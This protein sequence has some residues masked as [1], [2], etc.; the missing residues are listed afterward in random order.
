MN[1][2][3]VLACALALSLGAACSS[4]LNFTP[5]ATA[6]TVGADL[7]VRAE[8]DAAQHLTRVRVRAE[9]LA[10]PGR[11]MPEGR[12][13][14]VWARANANTTWVR[15][16]TLVYDT[17][18]RDGELNATVP[19]TSFELMVTAESSAEVPTPSD[20]VVVTQRVGS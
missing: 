7:K 16:G 19:F 1:I 14:V 4:A 6:L 8:I 15:V 2:R 11:L 18:D 12:L 3:T 17:D 20:K 10:P 13:F 9:N 5:T